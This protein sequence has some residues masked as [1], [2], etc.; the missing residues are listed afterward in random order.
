MAK[1]A[2][3]KE[4][5]CVVGLG[6]IGLPLAVSLANSGAE[7][8]GYDL[9]REIVD[10]VNKG[11]SHVFE[12]GLEETLRKVLKN[13]NFRATQLA[14]EMQKYK[15]VI[16]TVGTPTD[17][18]GYPIL[19]Q[20]E[21]A[22]KTI[23][24]NLRK[25]QVVI[26]KSTVPPLTT[27]EF[28]APLLEKASGLKL[29]ADFGIAFVP[30]RTI[31]GQAMR[32]L[33]TLTKVIGASDQKTAK[34]VEKLFK[35]LGGTIVKVSSPRIAELI[36]L[37]DN[38]YRDTNIALANEFAK[39]ANVLGLDVIEAIQAANKDY[40]RNKILIPGAGVGG[41]CLT[42][43]PLILAHVSEKAGESLPL[44]RVARK[45]NNEMPEKIFNLVR[46]VLK[47]NKR[48]IRNSKIAILGLTFKRDTN[49]LRE[50]PAKVI[51]DLLNREGA[52]IVLYDRFAFPEDVEKLFKTKKVENLE[53][54]CK[55]ADCLVIA[56][57]H[58]EFRELKLK[59][60]KELM[61]TPC[62]IDGRHMINPNFA[63]DLGFDFEGIGRPK[64]YFE[65]K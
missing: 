58:S 19:D 47:R 52:Q 50:T 31:E 8:V 6:F 3:S 30:E 33:K 15:F 34:E 26:L 22:A 44:I 27:E 28:V 46:S 14:S 41:S 24:E 65:R 45:V 16:I 64:E 57:D 21:S 48:E 9:R 13:G 29:G 42:K 36:K 5:V 25:G 4:K 37:M 18:N 17:S 62:I 11:Q 38:T 55:N 63:L 51:Y 53:E 7:V 2:K 39:A 40:E 32:E 12:P 49:D 23:G 1:K 60:I 54:A 35:S 59:R 56:T 20:V 61:R 10:R 43:D